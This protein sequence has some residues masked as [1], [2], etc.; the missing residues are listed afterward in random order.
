MSVNVYSYEQN[1]SRKNYHYKSALNFV[2]HSVEY[3]YG[4]GAA[5]FAF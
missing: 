5:V 3:I 4:L 1:Q 2:S